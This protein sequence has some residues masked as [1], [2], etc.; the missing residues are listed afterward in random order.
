MSDFHWRCQE[1]LDEA[2]A[3]I[4]ELEAERGDYIT[5]T[6]ALVVRVRG[7]SAAR[8]AELEAV[9]EK[10]VEC[11]VCYGNGQEY[12][13]GIGQAIGHMLECRKC[14]GTGRARPAP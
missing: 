13:Q 10:S 12:Y 5:E 4:A 9:L 7:E 8:I 11:P 2:K 3:R 6:E 1:A 14:R